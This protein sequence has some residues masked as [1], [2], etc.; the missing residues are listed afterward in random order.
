MISSRSEFSLPG[1]I[2][3][4]KQK[5]HQLTYQHL[6][7]KQAALLSAI[8]LGQRAALSQNIKDSFIQTGTIHILA[9]SGLHVGLISL[10]LIH[11]FNFLRLGRKPSFALTIVVLICYC[12]LLLL[13][14]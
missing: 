6:K 12:L 9:I 4:V 10:I 3:N 14:T 11:L 1:A 7:P 8:L 2:F 5:L 13:Y